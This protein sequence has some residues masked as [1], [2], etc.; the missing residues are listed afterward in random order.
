VSPTWTGRVWWRLDIIPDVPL[1]GNI[2]KRAREPDTNGSS[3]MASRHHSRCAAGRQYREAGSWARHER[4]KFE[5]TL[6]LAGNVWAREPEAQTFSFEGTLPLVGNVTGLVS[7][8]W[9][10]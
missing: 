6:P 5:G 2:E 8:V 9:Y 10:C 1:A 3:L 7:P 4:A